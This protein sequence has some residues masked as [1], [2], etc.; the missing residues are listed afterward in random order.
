LEAKDFLAS[1]SILKRISSYRFER[2]L[3]SKLKVQGLKSGKVV[4]IVESIQIVIMVESGLVDWL[5]R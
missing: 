5:I 3:S 4:T 2:N 1:A